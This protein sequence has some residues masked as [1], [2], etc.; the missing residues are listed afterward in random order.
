M[1]R[2]WRIIYHV[3]AH[4][5]VSDRYLDRSLI[6]L[7]FKGWGPIKIDLPLK[8]QGLHL[9]TMQEYAELALFFRGGP[10]PKFTLIN[11][12]GKPFNW[13]EGPEGLLKH[14][15][16]DLKLQNQNNPYVT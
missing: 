12:N 16:E 5:P 6:Y 4:L 3:V 13:E 10:K 2:L 8:K 7:G 15:M 9:M 11:R 1:K 14:D